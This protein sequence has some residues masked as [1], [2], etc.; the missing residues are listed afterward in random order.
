[1]RDFGSAQGVQIKKVRAWHEELL[2]FILANPRA[3]GAEIAFYFGVT[4][5]WVSTVKNS[6][7]FQEL[8]ARRRGEHFSRVSSTITEK[9][10]ALAEVTVDALTD[11][12][13]EQKRKGEVQVQTLKEVGEMALKALGFGAKRETA[14]PVIVN[15]NFTVDKETLARAREAKRL[16]IDATPTPSAAPTAGAERSPAPALSDMRSERE[17]DAAKSV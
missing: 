15:N 8:W 4:E 17:E 10:T 9:V 12:I 7:A 2:E 3:S 16:Y 5:A 6:D 1:M 11:K 14:S 13:E